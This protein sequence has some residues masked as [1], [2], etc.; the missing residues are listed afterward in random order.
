MLGSHIY[1]KNPIINTQNSADSQQSRPPAPPPLPTNNDRSHTLSAPLLGVQNCI[2]P[3]MFEYQE[4]FVGHM[5]RIDYVHNG[6]MVRI[7]YVH[8]GHMVRINYVHNGHTVLIDYVH[9]GHMVLIGY[10]HNGHTVRIGYVHNGH[11]V[12]IGYVESAKVLCT[13]LRTKTY[14]TC[15]MCT[16]RRNECRLVTFYFIIITTEVG[17]LCI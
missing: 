2:C 7:D 15:V 3:A 1:Y 11:M 14:Q 17:Y 8:N 13:W 16:T 5:V 6:H 9:N 10:V 12:R 4:N